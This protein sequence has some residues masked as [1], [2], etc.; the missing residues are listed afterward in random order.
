MVG[1]VLSCHKVLSVDQVAHLFTP[2]LV[3]KL[4]PGHYRGHTV[5]EWKH[6]E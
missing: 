6:G 3:H 4:S 1:H 2:E 5:V